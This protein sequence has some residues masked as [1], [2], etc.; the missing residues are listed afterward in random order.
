M[1][2]EIAPRCSYQFMQGRSSDQRE[3]T[4]FRNYRPPSEHGIVLAFDCVQYLLTTAAEQFYV[5]RQVPTD[6]TSQRKSTSKPFACPLYFKTHH[7][8]KCA[9]IFLVR[10]I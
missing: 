9:G 8:A 7:I 1:G 4:P 2:S 3:F 5:S 10:N 6:F